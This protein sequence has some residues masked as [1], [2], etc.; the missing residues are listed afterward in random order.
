M[1]VE[2]FASLQSRHTV[3]I[4]FRNNVINKLRTAEQQLIKD[5]TNMNEHSKNN[6]YVYCGKQMFSYMKKIVLPSIV[7]MTKHPSTNITA[8]TCVSIAFGVRLRNNYTENQVI[9]HLTKCIIYFLSA[10]AIKRDP[11]NG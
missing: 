2:K 6:C 3:R 1:M 5:N 11:I 8:R 4:P 7:V 10:A 9:Y